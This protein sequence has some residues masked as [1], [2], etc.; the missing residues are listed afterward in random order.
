MESEELKTW[1]EFQSL[2]GDIKTMAK[3]YQNYTQNRQRKNYKIGYR[4]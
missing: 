3:E 4:N 2:I 1:K